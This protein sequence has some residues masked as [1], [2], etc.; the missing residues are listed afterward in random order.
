M[1]VRAGANVNVRIPTGWTVLMKA[2]LWERTEVVKL[3]LQF[4]ADV[5]VED[6]EGWTA[7]SIA[8]AQGHRQIVELLRVAED[9]RHSTTDFADVH[10]EG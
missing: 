7:L 6:A 1:V 4:G 10:R 2:T 5:S 9:E 8:E 3:L